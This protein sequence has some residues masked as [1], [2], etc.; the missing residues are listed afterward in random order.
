MVGEDAAPPGLD[1]LGLAVVGHVERTDPL[2]LAGGFAPSDGAPL[3][4]AD[5]VTAAEGIAA[6]SSF[7]RVYG[8]VAPLDLERIRSLGVEGY[9]TRS[10]EVQDGLYRALPG[11]ILLAPDTVIRDEADRADR[12]ARRFALLG[13]SAAALLLGFA[14]LGA[15][16]LRRDQGELF[17]LLRRRGTGPRQIGALALL[18]AAVVVL[19]GALLGLLVGAAAAAGLGDRDGLDGAATAGEAVVGSSAGVLVLVLASL[20]LVAATLLWPADAD[21]RAWRLVDV[22]LVVSVLLIAVALSRGGVAVG[23]LDEGID[24]LLVLLPLLVALVTGLVAARLWPLLAR[25]V[26]HVLPRRWLAARLA[27]LGGCVSRYA[28]QGRRRS[29]RRRCARWSSRARTGRPWTRGPRTAPSSRPAWMRASRRARRS[30]RRCASGRSPTTPRS[31]LAGRRQRSSVRRPAHVVV[32]STPPRSRSSGSIRRSCRSIRRWDRVVGGG[33]P[34]AI[35]ALLRSRLPPAPGVELPEG[36]RLTVEAAGP[37]RDIAVTAWFRATDGREVG[38]PLSSRT[39]R[40]GRRRAP[41]G[42]SWTAAVPDLGPPVTLYRLVMRQ[43]TDD[44][45]RRQHRLGEGPVDLPVVEGTMVFAGARGRRHDRRRGVGG[46]GL[47]R[48]R[49]DG[50]AVDARR[51]RPADR[52]GVRGRPRAGRPGSGVAGHRRPRDCGARR[53]RP[54]GVADLGFRGADHGARR[55]HRAQVPDGTRPVRR[56]GRS[57]RLRAARRPRPW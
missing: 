50:G 22:V 20:A 45:T 47:A 4:V 40:P 31:P 34:V 52:S 56:R 32:P 16:G 21:G 19:L 54:D 13:G 5:G 51:G 14:V 35:A 17:T 48:W 36:G 1:Q 26:Q 49:D 53:R 55:R 29:S 41:G 44:A 15:V 24:P 37:L 3:L 18:E 30:S 57:R 12:S 46:V 23:S 39:G 33:D 28:W 8:W 25:P 43:P 9:L 38:V 27:L 7:Q 6:L 11:L 2:L 10:A 42:V